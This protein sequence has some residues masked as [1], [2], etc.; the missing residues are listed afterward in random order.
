MV[1]TLIDNWTEVMLRCLELNWRRVVSLQSCENFDFISMVGKSVDN[2]IVVDL[3]FTITLIVFVVYFSWSFLENRPFGFARLVKN[4]NN[5]IKYY[6][7]TTKKCP[8]IIS[9]VST[10]M[11][12]C[13]Q[14]VDQH[15]R[16]NSVIVKNIS[17]WQTNL[18]LCRT[19]KSERV[20]RDNIIGVRQMQT[21]D[22]QTGC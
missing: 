8:S 3:F 9:M 10:F 16:N 19:N 7:T 14:P 18:T 2:K 20:G 1:Y 11:G 5:K 17:Y 21:T 12:H 22:L 15:T 6:K 13:S 4:K